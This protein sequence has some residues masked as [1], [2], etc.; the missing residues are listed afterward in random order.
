MPELQTTKTGQS[1][2]A[3]ISSIAD[4]GRRADC[5]AVLQI[6]REV[7]KAEP[8]MWG[9]SIV[10]IG[11]YRYTYSNG[12]E[13]DWFVAGFSPRKQNL[14]IYITGGFDRHDEIMSRL[15]RHTTGKGCLYVKRLSDI[16]C[17]VL[18]EL[19]GASAAQLLTAQPSM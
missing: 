19:V 7:L 3:F 5:A 14:T 10:G 4:E 11:H 15:G 2:D 8:Q 16:D 12:R 6:M 1:V 17:A 13:N 18:R 9:S